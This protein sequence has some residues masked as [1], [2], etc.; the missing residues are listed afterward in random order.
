M[1]VLLGGALALLLAL[2]ELL[3]PPLAWRGSNG[4]AAG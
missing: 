1:L 3:L 4:G 2:V